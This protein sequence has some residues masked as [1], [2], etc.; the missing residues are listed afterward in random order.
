MNASLEREGGRPPRSTI[1]TSTRFEVISSAA[2]GDI[3]CSAIHTVTTT[4]IT[5]TRT[6]EVPITNWCITLRQHYQH[7]AAAVD[8]FISSSQ[9]SSNLTTTVINSQQQQQTNWCQMVLDFR[10]T[11]A[12]QIRASTFSVEEKSESI[13]QQ[14]TAV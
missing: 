13:Q 8:V 5:I 3:D 1:T 11:E 7:T 14:T 6:I 10:A 2:A 12:N 4:T 9:S